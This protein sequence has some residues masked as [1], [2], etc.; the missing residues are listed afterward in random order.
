VGALRRAALVATALV[1]TACD[2][3]SPAIPTLEVP[4]ASADSSVDE[5]AAVGDASGGGETSIPVIYTVCP[6]AMT[7]TFPSIFAQML[8]TGSCGVNQ[9]FDCH[10]AS[11]AS[12]KADGGTGSL[13]DFSLDAAAVYGELLGADGG[14]QPSTNIGGD[15]GRVVL[16]VAPGDADA[17]LLYIKLALPTLQDPRYGKAMPPVGLVCPSALDAVKAWIDNGATANP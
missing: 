5:S 16:R 2:A 14:G 15:A 12:P 1:A 10:S 11:G 13:L 9:S 17:S 4:D 6:D 7:A 8:A 3:G